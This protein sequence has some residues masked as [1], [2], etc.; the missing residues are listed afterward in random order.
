MSVACPRAPCMSTGRPPCGVLSMSVPPV[1]NVTAVAIAMYAVPVRAW[2]ARPLQ[3]AARC[4]EHVYMMSNC[5]TYRQ[6]L[7]SLVNST[8]VGC[9]DVST[10]PNVSAPNVSTPNVTTP[11][12]DAA[13]VDEWH[14]WTMVRQYHL[15]DQMSFLRWR[16]LS[17]L[18]E[19]KELS[20]VVFVDCDVLIFSNLAAVIRS[21]TLLQRHDALLLGKAG[22]ISFWSAR[23]LTAYVAFVDH[24]LHSCGS[25]ALLAANM[26][27][28]M[29]FLGL[30]RHVL[31]PTGFEMLARINASALDGICQIQPRSHSAPPIS[32]YTLGSLGVA[33]EGFW[34]GHVHAA[35][36]N[37]A[38]QTC[39]GGNSSTYGVYGELVGH[40]DRRFGRIPMLTVHVPPGHCTPLV[41][42]V[43][44]RTLAPLHAAHYLGRYKAYLTRL[45][46][47]LA[48]CSV[49]THTS[50]ALHVRW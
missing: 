50:G 11:N 27:S 4:N 48:S 17:W 23:G 18:M 49:C 41:Q 14:Q 31:A 44:T 46:N 22:S 47:T 34:M 9:F 25:Q 5:S 15:M 37:P 42:Q 32:A 20:H 13:P 39:T 33:A 24:L 40:P 2:H 29:S 21:S 19:S 10:T 28:D 35:I 43:C 3:M 45:P 1:S 12:V 36:V 26:G 7:A 30:W 38:N 6:T 8:R 16:Q